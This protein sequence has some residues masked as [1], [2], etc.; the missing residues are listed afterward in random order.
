MS[1]CANKQRCPC[2]KEKESVK[3]SYCCHAI[4]TVLQAEDVERL[5]EEVASASLS[6]Q[7]HER[8]CSS[9]TP[10][11]RD[12]LQYPQS[13]AGIPPDSPSPYCTV[14]GELDD[15]VQ[16][17]PPVQQGSGRSMPCQPEFDQGNQCRGNNSADTPNSGPTA[18][19]AVHGAS[20][21]QGQTLWPPA[22]CSKFQ[23]A[24]ARAAQAVQGTWAWGRVMA[25]LPWSGGG[26]LE[27][28]GRLRVGEQGTGSS[29][30]PSSGGSPGRPH[31]GLSLHAQSRETEGSRSRATDLAVAVAV[32][33]V[34]YAAYRERKVSGMGR[35]VQPWFV[36]SLAS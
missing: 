7:E 25:G 35:F 12:H 36:A 23:G 30:H 28:G 32:A 29:H 10:P 31:S 3:I 5:R 34:L 8:M 15:D 26:Q 16:R 24:C 17:Q 1:A 11:H 6:G 14:L 2:P 4:Q 19:E 18:K 20:V 27:T 22:L 21:C 13:W 33:A 9:T